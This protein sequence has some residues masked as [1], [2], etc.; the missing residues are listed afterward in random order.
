MNFDSIR[1]A[2]LD[3]NKPLDSV[4]LE[5]GKK[6]SFRQTY[7]FGLNLSSGILL[8]PYSDLII[9]CGEPI[10][11]FDPSLITLTEDSVA[12]TPASLTR[13]TTSP[14]KLI[15][16]YHWKPDSKYAL[17]IDDDAV[18]DVFGVKSK[19]Y[20]KK[21]QLDKED[22]YSNLTL[23]VT[24]PDTSKSYIV[25][26]YID[27][28][29]PL[30]RNEIRKNSDLTYKNFV[31]SKYYIRVIYDDNRN[32]KWDTGNVKKRQY[33]E[34]IWIDPVQITLRPNWDEEEKLDIP[35]EQIAP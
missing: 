1:V 28:K 31:T 3:N 23:H 24:V 16:K 8:K 17:T 29:F 27:P 15:L 12:I 4:S 35:R 26:L 19:R 11:T 10:D 34:N 18:T 2:I 13:D 21:F 7:T 30:A 9:T 22:N 25:E 20:Y 32:G 5:K 33:P 6:E 14:R